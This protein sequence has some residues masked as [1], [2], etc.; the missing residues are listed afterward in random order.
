VSPK[1]GKYRAHQRSHRV[2]PRG[3]AGR[4]SYDGWGSRSSVS[5]WV[6]YVIFVALWVFVMWSKTRR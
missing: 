1:G 6:A 3:P 5:A 2:A 4:N